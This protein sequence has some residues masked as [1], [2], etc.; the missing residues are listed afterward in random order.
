MFTIL[1]MFIVVLLYI[2]C[3]SARLEARKRNGACV[4]GTVRFAYR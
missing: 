3:S 1:R 4:R 2:F